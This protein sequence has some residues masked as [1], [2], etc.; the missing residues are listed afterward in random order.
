MVPN[1]FDLKYKYYTIVVSSINIATL[2][3]MD[4]L[5]KMTLMKS[6]GKELVSSS[7]GLEMR[8]ISI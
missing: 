7:V 2:A 5:L 8:Y 3:R 6:S 4:L 1:V